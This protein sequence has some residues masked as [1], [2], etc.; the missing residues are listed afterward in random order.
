MSVTVVSVVK[1]ADAG[2]PTTLITE[3]G[4]MNFSRNDGVFT[5]KFSFKYPE[6]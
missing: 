3:K 6:P 4:T 5:G 2:S 1:T